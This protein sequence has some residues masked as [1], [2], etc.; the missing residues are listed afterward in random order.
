MTACKRVAKELEDLQKDLPQYLRNL[1]SDDAD[2]LVWHALLLPEKPPY[3]LRA[4][5]LRINFPE[6]YPMRPPTVTF[7]TKIYHPTV[8]IDGQVCLPIISNENWKPSTKTYQV[9]EALSVLVNNPDLGEPVRLELA[10]LLTLD[11]EQFHRRA[12]EF[13]LQ[14]GEPR[15]S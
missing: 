5:S 2:V 1:S 10:D 3:N 9:L 6:E 12:E 15:P 14:F 13:T 11:S 8:G 7:T 4:F